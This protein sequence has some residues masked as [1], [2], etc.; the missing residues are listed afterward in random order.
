[1]LTI[2]VNGL[3]A[4]IA[5]ATVIGVSLDRQARHEAWTRI[6]HWR[7]TN[8]EHRR[9]LEELAV[10][11]DVREAAAD[12]RERR[13]EFREMQLIHFEEELRRLDVGPQERGRTA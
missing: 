12:L 8:A 6:A 2:V 1:M 3:F 4:L 10:Q 9:E 7:R 13:V 5:L 11:L